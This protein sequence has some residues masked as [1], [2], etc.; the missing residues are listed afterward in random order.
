M[1]TPDCPRCH[2]SQ[3]VVPLT[4]RHGVRSDASWCSFC[5][6]C[7]QPGVPLYPSHSFIDPK[8]IGITVEVRGLDDFVLSLSGQLTAST[9]AEACELAQTY[10]QAIAERH[11]PA[12]VSEADAKLERIQTLLRESGA[13]KTDPEDFVR[14]IIC[15]CHALEEKLRE[16][17]DELAKKDL[18]G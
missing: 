17:D 1:S 18:D 3:H 8:Y 4:I 15:R 14:D 2:S 10:E 16:I 9:Y 12:V 13:P 6:Q 7:F 11:R 5:Q